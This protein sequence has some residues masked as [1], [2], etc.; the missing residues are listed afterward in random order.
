MLMDNNFEYGVPYVNYQFLKRGNEF[1]E[2]STPADLILNSIK[3]HHWQVLGDVRFDWAGYIEVKLYEM[4]K[5]YTSWERVELL[6]MGHLLKSH[7]F[8]TKEE[9]KEYTKWYL[10]KRNL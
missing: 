2:V 4:E 3:I 10:K 5:D 8:K 1:W 9:A 6:S 7:Y